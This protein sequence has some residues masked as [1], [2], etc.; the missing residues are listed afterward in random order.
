MEAVYSSF[1]SYFLVKPSLQL[2]QT[3]FFVYWK[4][5]FI[6]KFFLLV[7][8]IIGILG[9]QFS[10]KE[11]NIT[12]AQLIFWLV[13][14]HFFLHFSNFSIKPFISSR[15]KIPFHQKKWRIRVKNTFISVR[16]TKLTVA[17][18]SE[19]GRKKSSLLATKLAS[20]SS[21]K[22]VLQKS[23][24]KSVNKR[25]LFLLN[26]KSVPTDRNIGKIK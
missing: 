15:Q 5:C 25:I 11:L 19:S 4:D 7:E 16:K 22:V 3:S 13:K 9:K 26:R 6:L 10:T 20:T 14:N 1:A 12:S 24:K 17:G 23:R 18:M 2:V 8:T 21:N